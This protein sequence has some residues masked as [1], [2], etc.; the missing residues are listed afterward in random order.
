MPGLG[1]VNVGTEE[2][3]IAKVKQQRMSNY[4]NNLKSKV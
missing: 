2:W 1:P 3:N 4:V